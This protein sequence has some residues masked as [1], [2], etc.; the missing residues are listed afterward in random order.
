[1]ADNSDQRRFSSTLKK[2]TRVRFR[3]AGTVYYDKVHEGEVELFLRD[4]GVPFSGTT[5]VLLGDSE[6]VFATYRCS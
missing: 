1:M 4:L 6:T 2:P 3:N 5:E